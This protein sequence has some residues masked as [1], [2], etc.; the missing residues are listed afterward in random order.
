[1]SLQK[2]KRMK[3][4]H[5]E[6]LTEGSGKLW[7]VNINC[8]GIVALTSKMPD[9]KMGEESAIQIKAIEKAIMSV[10]NTSISVSGPIFRMTPEALQKHIPL[11]K[12][13][14]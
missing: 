13:I 14:A 4:D 9:L 3:M 5:E 11:V 12:D 7:Q 6:L 8:A 10:S 1:M 2:K